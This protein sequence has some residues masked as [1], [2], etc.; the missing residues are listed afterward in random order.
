MK[1]SHLHVHT[2]YSLLDGAAS[3]PALYDKAIKDGMPALAISDHGNMFGVFEF[4]K[5]AYNHTNEDGSLKVKPIVGCEFY[6]TKNRLQKT[7]SKGNRDPRHHQIMWAKNATGYKN[8]I[9]LTS[10]GYLE[11]MYSK[12][13]RIDK[14]LVQKY[15]EGLIAS[16]CCIGA[17]VPQAILNEGEEAAENEFKWWLNIFQ[18]DYYIEIQR[19]G[20]PEQEKVN[21]LL[22]KFAEKYK[23]KIIATNDSHY[24]NREDAEAHDILLCINTGSKQTDEKIAGVDDDVAGKQ[25]RFAFPNDQFFLKKTSE[26][27]AVF[28]DLPEAIDN[29]N[30]VIGK[31]DTLK[32]TRDILLPYFEVPPQYGTQDE[33]LAHLTWEGAKNRYREITAEIEERINFEL[34]T[35]R[36]MGFAG[37]FLIVSDYVNAGKNM[38]VFVGPGRGSAAGSVVAYCIGIT[39]VDPM[40][41]KLLFER[42]LNPGRNS[43]PDIDIDFDD[44]GRQKIMDYVVAKYGKNQVAQVITYGTMAAKSSIKDVARVLDLPLS[45]SNALTKLVPDKPGIALKKVLHGALTGEKSLADDGLSAED[46]EH[47]NT[48]RTM[49][50]GD[51]LK[52]KVLKEAEILEGSIRNTGVHASAIIIAPED[53]MTIMPV[54]ISRDSPLWLT[55]IDG[56]NIESA[57]VIKMDFLGLRTLTI[58]K[59]SLRLVKKNHGVD[60]D[61]DALPL[62]DEATYGVFQRGETNGLFQFESAG[63]QKYLKELKPDKFDDLIAMNALY[64]P[65][66]IAYI[67]DY[68]ERKHGRQKIEYD[69]PEMEEF[70]KDTYGITVYQEQVMLLSQKLAGFSKSQADD[71]RK[72]MGKKKRKVL[73]KMKEEFMKGGIER[74]HPEKTLDKIWHD[75]EAFAR[76][77]FNKSHSTC[78]AVLAYQTAYLK[79]HYPSEFMAALLNH[80]GNTEKIAFLIE[81][82]RSI[83]IKVLGPDINESDSGFSVNKKGEI[84]IGLSGIKGVSENAVENI[85]GERE[86]NGSFESIFDLVKRVNHRAANKKSLENMAVAGCFDCFQGMHRSRFFYRANGDLMN[87]LEKIVRFGDQYQTQL[88]NRVA[89]LFGDMHMDTIAHPELPD[90]QPWSLIE[91][92]EKE[93][94]VIGL[95]LSGHPLDN[96]KF[97]LKHYGISKIRDIL[98]YRDILILKKGSSKTLH[99]AGLVNAA[100]HRISKKGT[101]FGTFIIEDYEG[102][103]ELTL[104]SE[105]YSKYGVLLEKGNIVYVSGVY[106]QRYENDEYRFQ[107]QEVLL[108][109]SLMKRHTKSV[110]VKLVAESVS[111]DTVS[112][113]EN[114]IRRNPGATRVRI[115][116]FDP[117]SKHIVN[118]ARSKGGITMNADLADYASVRP[119]M[120]L[121]VESN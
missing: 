69:L 80:A 14:E 76:Y 89:T 121:L 68:I 61:L 82:C 70:L 109:E 72:A 17:S 57:G 120:E 20:L 51:D 119:D 65:G 79:A 27:T 23:V 8:L 48:I 29:T 81:E 63:M 18:D 91:R 4:V 107:V 75:W 97:E 100:N 116:V 71:L 30:E 24:V 74:G 60:I 3:I 117:V 47:I 99:F 35:I 46:F 25:R 54:A 44:D 49:Y 12:Y 45:E 111:M 86:K 73:D 93:K 85:V 101:K 6:I 2:Q 84:R 88:N 113:L 103:M 62:D 66:P 52:A 106:R 118:L 64:R 110:E 55:Q 59:T 78:Y 7:F 42:F 112:F 114:N 31:I 98:N 40:K 92:L 41:Y 32:L 9:K 10:L 19:H 37:Y 50:S 1:F 56:S 36:T 34:F 104:W 33:Y 95:Y 83:N 58:L 21:S 105:D 43:M 53:L 102:S 77:A 39:N 11:G 5:N 108:L 67:P 13:P 26:M 22:L 115:S 15:H 96:Y 87:A 94:E 90:C 38:G 16:T 28:H